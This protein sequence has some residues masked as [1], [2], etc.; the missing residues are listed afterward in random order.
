MLE[1]EQPRIECIERS[2]DDSYAK[3]VV[4]PLERG[5]G[6]TLGNSLRRILLSS[7]PGSAVTSVKIEGVLHEPS[8]IP[9]VLEDVTG[10][11]L[12]LKSLV[13]QGHT[14]EPWIIRVEAEGPGVVTAGDIITDPDLD[15][16]NPELKIAT[17]EKDGRL[18]M[19]MTVERG[20]GY[21]SA[22]KNMVLNNGIGVIAI[23]SIFAPIYKVN[24]EIGATRVGQITD[25]D[26]LT[27]EVWSNGSISPEKAISEAARMMN[28]QLSLFMGLTGNLDNVEVIVEKK[29]EPTIKILD[30]EIEDFNLSVRTYNGLKRAGVNTLGD[31]TRKTVEEMTKMRNLGSKSFDEVEL[32]LTELGLSF[33]PEEE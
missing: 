8:A 12:N 19:E 23:D 27:L 25:Y 15:I 30:M 1:I 9:G 22:D 18:F 7:L 33:R 28:D 6:I 24:Y 5:Y 16:L 10:I 26:K 29:E 17:L 2:E 13:L 20:R 3:F 32:K 14:D 4:E 21:V 11:I 31:L